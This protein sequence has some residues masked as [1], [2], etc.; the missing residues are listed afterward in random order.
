MTEEGNANLT[1]S[2][3]NLK[4]GLQIINTE[5]RYIYLNNAAVNQSKHTRDELMSHT[6]LEL[7]P[8]IENTSLFKT[9]KIC[10]EDK[11]FT[12]FLNKFEFPDGSISWFELRIQPVQEGLLILSVDV[13]DHEESDLEKKLFIDQLEVVL[14]TTPNKVKQPLS[15]Y[16]SF[17]FLPAYASLSR[18]DIQNVINHLK[19]SAITIEQFTKELN[20][21]ISM[22][23][24]RSTS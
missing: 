14:A 4:Q 16:S 17:P 1:S 24:L 19:E 10:M 7:Y 8:G 5:W 11:I 13:T 22:S 20:Q 18:E 3:H 12:N 9:M 23:L 21:Y 15:N 6:M 2:I